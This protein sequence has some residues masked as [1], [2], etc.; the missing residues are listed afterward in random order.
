MSSMVDAEPVRQHVRSLMA[1]GLG[2]KRVAQIAGVADQSVAY[3]LYGDPRNEKRAAKRIHV[4][5]A[6]KLLA[7][8]YNHDLRS[9]GSR[10]D[11]TGTRRR[12]QALVAQGWT[13]IELANR[14]DCSTARV[15][16]LIKGY[17]PSVYLCTHREVVEIHRELWD[18]E[19]PQET[20]QQTARVGRAKN[21]ARKY[22][23]TPT[24]AWDDIDNPAEDPSVDAEPDPT[25][26]DTV[27][28][29]NVIAGCGAPSELSQV[30]RREAAK[31]LLKAGY[32]PTTVGGRLN[33]SHH[34]V[35]RIMEEAA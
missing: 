11:G 5:N 14:L 6:K 21:R 20:P 32:R 29:W 10:V 7:V 13:N 2:R 24:A 12:L 28:V 19:P 31:L 15:N 26:V 16:A 27:R 25:Y 34:S 3:L 22:G 8:Q 30:E 35:Q 33:M 1:Q 17:S 18:K 23:Y 9:D 4:M